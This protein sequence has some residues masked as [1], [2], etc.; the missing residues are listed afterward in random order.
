MQ[1]DKARP[2]EKQV[3]Q[4]NEA[5]EQLHVDAGFVADL[6][7]HHDRVHAVHDRA[8]RGHCVA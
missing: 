2:E 8:E 7:L 4:A 3:K 6:F 5:E 1:D